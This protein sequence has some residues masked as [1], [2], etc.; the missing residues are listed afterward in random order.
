M[1]SMAFR[2]MAT[3]CPASSLRTVKNFA[4]DLFITPVRFSSGKN[5]IYGLPLIKTAGYFYIIRS[6]VV[7]ECHKPVGADCTQRLVKGL[8]TRKL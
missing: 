5:V 3:E 6:F 4:A 7:Q 8:D 1:V 2:A